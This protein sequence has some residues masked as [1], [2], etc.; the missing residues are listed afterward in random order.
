[1]K[2]MKT[3]K[4]VLILVATTVCMASAFAKSITVKVGNENVLVDVP[5]DFAGLVESRLP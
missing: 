3:K 5:D 4:I 2:T 1:M